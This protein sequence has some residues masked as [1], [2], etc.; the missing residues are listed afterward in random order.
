M[1]EFTVIIAAFVLFFYLIREPE[2]W[3]GPGYF[4]KPRYKH[5]APWPFVIWCRKRSHKKQGC[6]HSGGIARCIGCG[7][8]VNRE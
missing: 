8:I 5:Y 1:L 2:K 3:R 4:F 6:W 7:D